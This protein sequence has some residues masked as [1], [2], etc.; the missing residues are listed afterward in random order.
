MT[1][2]FPIAQGNL[3][4]YASMSV[5]GGQQNRQIITE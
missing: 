3:V 5:T 2:L 1:Q 4:K